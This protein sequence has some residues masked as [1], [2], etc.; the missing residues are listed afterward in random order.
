MLFRSYPELEPLGV[1]IWAHIERGLPHMDEAW[2]AIEQRS[3]R[4][5]PPE[6]RASAHHFPPG[7]DPRQEHQ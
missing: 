2:A 1:R 7:L 6:V 3:K 5:V 4:K